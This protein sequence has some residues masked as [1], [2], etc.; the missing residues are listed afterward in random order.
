MKSIF[1]LSVCLVFALPN[2]LCNYSVEKEERNAKIIIL[3]DD[4]ICTESQWVYLRGYK[5]WISGNE[6]AIFDSVFIEKGEHK[7][8]LNASI[9]V[10]TSLFLL[11]S[12]YGP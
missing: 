2:I 1:Y 5:D 3:V 10:A 11:F 6:V 9:C 8:V 7:A 12:K 4:Y